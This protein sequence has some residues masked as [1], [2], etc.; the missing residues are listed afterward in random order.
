V[1]VDLKI[2]RWLSNGLKIS[3]LGN[4]PEYLLIW[5]IRLLKPVKKLS[6]LQSCTVLKADFYA[7]E[8]RTPRVYPG[9]S[10]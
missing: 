5:F 3:K 8:D 10:I 1:F 9:E 2:K 7:V 6:A 4:R